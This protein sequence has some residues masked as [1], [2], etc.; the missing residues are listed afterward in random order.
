MV[1]RRRLSFSLPLF[2]FALAIPC[3]LVISAQTAR[4]QSYSVLHTFTYNDG[5]YPT[6]T[7]VQ[8]R[9]G[10]FYG[11]AENGGPG[12]GVLFQLKRAGSGWILRP[13]HG[14]APVSS[15][16]EPLNYGG[17]TFG[18]DGTLYGTAYS[19]GLL[20]CGE[21]QTYCGVAFR[22][23]PPPT[24]CTSA[25]CPWYYTVIYQFTSL[26]DIGGP[27]A[28]LVFDASGQIYSTGLYG[29]IYQLSPSGGS[30]NESAIYQLPVED[31]TNAGLIK[32]SA[33]NLYGTWWSYDNNGGVFEL[34][35]S[36]SGWTETVLYSFTGGSDGSDPLGGLIFDSAGNLYG[37]TSSGG[38]EGGGAVFELS[39]SSSGWT[40]QLVCSSRGYTRMSGPQSALTM[41]SHGN[42]Y[43]TTY[44]GGGF[45][46]GEAFKATRI[47]NNWSCSDLYD[48]QV[49][50][51]GFYPIAGVTVDSQG[52]LYGTTSVGGDSSRCIAD[53]GCG[54]V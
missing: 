1:S 9:A 43:G 2:V 31:Y 18:P 45:G 35:P 40:Y 23:Q 16:T 20:E 10:N 15:G 53:Q 14:F 49:G 6:S 30:W 37:S 28:S 11:T 36:P 25:L 17:L 50:S 5:A 48:F 3:A 7:L 19:G 26:T 42:L 51:D 44:S 13:L 8:D 33:G 54:V 38:T 39:P 4:A 22:L 29:T 41:D 21:G 12:G 47:G 34:S 46:A 27:R 24:A 52:N 32:D